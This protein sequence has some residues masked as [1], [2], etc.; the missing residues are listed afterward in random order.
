MRRGR[1]HNTERD[2][3]VIEE[4]A[5]GIPRKD[6]SAKHEIGLPAIRKIVTAHNKLHKPVVEKIQPETSTALFA[7]MDKLIIN[8]FSKIGTVPRIHKTDD[9]LRIAP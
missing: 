4:I 6:I 9:K 7:E 5:K 8:F 2:K 1:K 3:Q